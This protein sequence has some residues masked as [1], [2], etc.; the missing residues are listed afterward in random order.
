MTTGS[1]WALTHLLLRC[2]LTCQIFC[3]GVL[4]SIEIPPPK[5]DGHCDDG[6]EEAE[7]HHDDDDDVLEDVLDIVEAG[8]TWD[9]VAVVTKGRHFKP[10]WWWRGRKIK[11][12]R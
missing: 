11:Y 7:G 12:R 2:K 9:T 4:P 5:D 8:D 1:T 6:D 10:W 3:T